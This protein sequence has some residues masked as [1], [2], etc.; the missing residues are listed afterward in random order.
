MARSLSTETLPLPLAAAIGPWIA[1][2]KTAS[3][4]MGEEVRVT[5]DDAVTSLRARIVMTALLETAL[6]EA[7]IATVVL[8]NNLNRRA[9]LPSKEKAEALTALD[10]LIIRLQ[11]QDAKPS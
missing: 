1:A 11:D 10:A 3:R 4:G 9:T 7:R 2:V 8:A 6:I 5:A